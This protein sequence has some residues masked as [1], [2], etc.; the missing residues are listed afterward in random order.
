MVVRSA[1]QRPIPTT[2]VLIDVGRSTSGSFRRVRGRGDSADDIDR[3]R[4]SRGPAPSRGALPSTGHQLVRI[5]E[6]HSGALVRLSAGTSIGP[7][8]SPDAARR[9][10]R[11]SSSHGPLRDDTRLAS[12]SLT[13]TTVITNG[14]RSTVARRRRMDVDGRQ[15]GDGHTIWRS[16]EDTD[17]C[18]ATDRRGRRPNRQRL[19][20]WRIVR[21]R[22]V[23]A[24]ES[25]AGSCAGPSWWR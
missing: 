14:L 11:V 21:Q 5:G 18:R 25:S 7:R 22:I 8:P 23:A 15:E 13:T 9:E 17:G 16:Q 4:S 24:G 6:G 2:L 1:L 12:S 10:R 3:T 20:R 19:G